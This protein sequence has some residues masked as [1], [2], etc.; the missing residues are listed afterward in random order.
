MMNPIIVAKK[1]IFRHLFMVKFYG[2]HQFVN[3]AIFNKNVLT[4][5]ISMLEVQQGLYFFSDISLQKGKKI[6]H[7]YPRF[8]SLSKI[9][10]STVYICS[11]RKL[12]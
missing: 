12:I 4:F 7:V 11:P 3:F 9:S 6:M 5:A 8:R 2:C 1:V 10:M